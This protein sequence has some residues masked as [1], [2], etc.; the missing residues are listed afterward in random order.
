MYRSELH[1]VIK[2]RHTLELSQTAAAEAS[3]RGQLVPLYDGLI[4]AG[5]DGGCNRRTAELFCCVVSKER[6]KR[7]IYRLTSDGSIVIDRPLNGQTHRT[8][9]DDLTGR[10]ERRLRQ[11]CKQTIDR[12]T[13]G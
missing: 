4:I 6:R 7:S 5:Q 1:S 3:C 13:D 11:T 2:G 9:Q 10:Q 8:M 12:Q